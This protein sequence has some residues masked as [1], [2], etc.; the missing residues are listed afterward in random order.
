MAPSAKRK[1]TISQGLAD[2][3]IHQADVDFVFGGC[4][5]RD[6]EFRIIKKHYFRQA[7]QLHPDKGGDASKFR[8]VQTSFELLRDLHGGKKKRKQKADTW[9]F[10]ECFKAAVGSTTGKYSQDDDTAYGKGEE[11][12][13]DF[14]MSAYDFDFSSMETPSWQYYEGAADEVVPTYRV[15]LAKST[16]SKCNAKSKAKKCREGLASSNIAA[17]EDCTDLVDLK[18]LPELIAKNEVRCGWLNDQSGTYSR[19]TH[20]RCWRVPQLVWLGLPDPDSCHDPTKFALALASMDECILSG[21]TDLPHSDQRAFVDH[22]RNKL[23]WTRKTKKKK[24]KAAPADANKILEASSNIVTP[25]PVVSDTKVNQAAIVTSTS[26]TNLVASR[27]RFVV[28]KPGENGASGASVFSGK[29]FVLTGLFPEV[30]GG[31]GLSMGKDKVKS[32]V[33]SFGGRVTGSISGKTNVLV[34]GKDPG[35]SKVSKARAKNNILLVSLHDLKLGLDS[36]AVALENFAVATRKETMKIQSFS[37]GYSYSRGGHNGMVLSASKIELAIAQ[38]LK[39][40]SNTDK[41][42]KVATEKHKVLQDA[43]VDTASDATSKRLKIGKREN[44]ESSSPELSVKNKKR[45]INKTKKAA[46]N[47]K[48]KAGTSTVVVMK[49]KEQQDIIT[50]DKCGHV[51]TK[52]SWFIASKEEDYCNICHGMYDIEGA[53]LQRNGHN[54]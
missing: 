9:F 22:C 13:E 46:K 19:W 35:M 16:R 44:G 47:K 11:R 34:V 52:Q 28:P 3:G 42:K 6:E 43:I 41:T 49:E 7:L 26:S 33:Q 48:T 23:N 38:G 12:E 20:L 50:C 4:N 36:G 53:V 54:V 14:D 25:D 27:K 30:G 10:S 37:K 39:P 45:S 17:N 18:A 15:E 1:H 31:F 5:T 24:P 29:T 40:H 8:T 51:C 2:L 21:V 32:M